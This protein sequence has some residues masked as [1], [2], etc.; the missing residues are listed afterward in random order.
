M[1]GAIVG[2]IAGS[3]YE[4]NRNKSKNFSPFLHPSGGI[5]DDTIMTVAIADSLL[6]EI[7]PAVSM[8]HWARTVYP[9]ESLGGYGAGF[10]KWLS[11]SEV[12]PPYN[13]Y[14]N[15][16]AMRVSPVGWLFDDLEI[17]LE[18]AKL[19]TIVSHSHPE[20]IKGAQAVVLAMNLARKGADVQA[21]REAVQDMFGYQMDRSVDVCREE[22]FYNETCQHYVPDAIICA[23]EASCF[24]DAIR[25]AV[26]L[27]G[28][29]D[30]LAAIAGGLAEVIFGIPQHIIDN[31]APY[32]PDDLRPVLDQFY[33]AVQTSRI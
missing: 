14:G 26:S 16:A 27:G 11:A 25:N 32:L 9:T 8:R 6:N 17:A 20:G 30:T 24:E 4:F 28:D 3:P 2:D 7:P 18:V 22:H 10:M 23:L 13:S 29:A 5:T 1:Y 33:L 15:G 19:V 21:I 12:Q 31:V